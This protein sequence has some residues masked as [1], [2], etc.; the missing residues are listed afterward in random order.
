MEDQVL[1]GGS[2]GPQDRQRKQVLILDCYAIYIDVYASKLKE[3]EIKII[4]KN[5][6]NTYS[7]SPIGIFGK[8]KKYN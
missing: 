3:R 8:Q 1:D 6:Q 7:S 2:S 4:N 5:K